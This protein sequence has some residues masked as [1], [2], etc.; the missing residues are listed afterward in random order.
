MDEAT[1]SNAFERNAM[2]DYRKLFKQREAG[3]WQKLKEIK[4]DYT[5]LD[6]IVNAPAVDMT[7]IR[8]TD[9][10]VAAAI[11]RFYHNDGR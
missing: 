6:V 1:D 9:Q 10:E 5:I 7:D 4:P 2:R 11:D 8:G 3:K